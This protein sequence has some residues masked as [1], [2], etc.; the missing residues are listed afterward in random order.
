M[1]GSREK[2]LAARRWR[3]WRF[4]EFRLD[5]RERRLER[6]GRP[7]ALPPKQFDLL[8]LFLSNAGQ[9]VR[10]EDLIAAL[11]PGV[12]VE[13]GT[14]LRHVSALRKALG[15]AFFETLP[16]AGYRWQVGDRVRGA[17]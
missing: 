15:A 3:I 2:T 16:K 11:W 5:E 12:F 6:A 4:D 1:T 17:R 9:L 10:K 8:V 14:P 7:V 13:D